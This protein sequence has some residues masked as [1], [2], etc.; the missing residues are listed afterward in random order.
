MKR[1][2][3]EGGSTRMVEV[4]VGLYDWLDSNLRE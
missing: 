4:E 2:R 3:T 1:T